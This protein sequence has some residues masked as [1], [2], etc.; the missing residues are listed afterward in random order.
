L[1]GD[2]VKKNQVPYATA[3]GYP[4][5]QHHHLHNYF[6]KDPNLGFGHGGT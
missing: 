6:H 1:Q 3:V 2:F 4:K 5:E